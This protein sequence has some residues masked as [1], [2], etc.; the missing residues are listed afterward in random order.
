M[1]SPGVSVCLS[2]PRQELKCGKGKHSGFFLGGEVGR[3]MCW[4]DSVC[5]KRS[6]SGLEHGASVCLYVCV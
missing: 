3:L 1:M 5:P 4:E 6:V 2:G